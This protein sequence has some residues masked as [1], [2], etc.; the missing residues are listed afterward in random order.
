MD[1]DLKDL[2]TFLTGAT[3]LLLGQQELFKKFEL[4]ALNKQSNFIDVMENCECSIF[5]SLLEESFNF[6]LCCMDES[7]FLIDGI[8]SCENQLAVLPSEY[9]LTNREYRFMYKDRY[10]PDT[11]GKFSLFVA[12][13]D[14]FNE[15]VQKIKRLKRGNN[16]THE[17]T[18][19]CSKK[20]EA[21][22]ICVDQLSFDIN[23]FQSSLTRCFKEAERFTLK[24]GGFTIY[25]YNCGT[26]V[27]NLYNIIQFK[28]R[29][30]NWN[31]DNSLWHSMSYAQRLELKRTIGVPDFFTV[32]NE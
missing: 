7:Q 5:L 23:A 11:E 30:P 22:D 8:I 25:G 31:L 17:F 3:T 29:R 4:E 10:Y 19:T 14:G 13:I 16:N 1:S 27:Q 12:C 32:N 18:R 26:R 28:T 9:V 15:F 21:L 24:G 2:F 6:Y 20:V